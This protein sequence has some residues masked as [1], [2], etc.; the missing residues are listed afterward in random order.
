MPS[1]I[2][3]YQCPACTGPLRYDGGSGKL[4]CDYC[5]SAFTVQEIEKLYQEKLDQA[6][7]AG[8]AQAAKEEAQA[9]AAAEAAQIGAEDPEW[10][11]AQAGMKAYTCPSC[12]AELICDATTAATSCPYCGNPTV[13]P[14]QFHG[15]LK[16]DYILPF[17]LDKEAAKKALRAFYKGK[18]L[19]PRAFTTDNHI[20]EI[21][22][23]YVPFWLFDG[24]GDADLNFTAT[25]VSTHRSGDYQV[26]VTDH[27]AVRR[28]GTVDFHRI[29]TDSSSKMP[30]AHMDA[31]EPFDFSELKPFSTAYMPGFLAERYDVDVAECEKRARRRAGNTTEQVIANTVRGYSSVTPVGKNVFM[32]RSAVSYVMLPVWMLSTRW[33]GKSFLFAMNGQTGKLIGDLPVSMGRFWGWFGA[34]AAPLAAIL[35]G[36]LFLAF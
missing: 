17:K 8:V 20:E 1:Q 25:R 4:V 24:Q 27:Y 35:T 13:V 9:A 10:D 29:P 23:V 7:A 2:T 34:I 32:R 31:I 28:A 5:G 11:L 22:G 33:K 15:M 21:K 26:T 6:E 3:N 12:A 36:L 14:A 30:D 18:R 19:L 16:P